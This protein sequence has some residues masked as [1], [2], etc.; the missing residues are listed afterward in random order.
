MNVIFC[1][2]AISD[3][4]NKLAD[5]TPYLSAR[6]SVELT[7]MIDTVIYLSAQGRRKGP[8]RFMNA[9]LSN[10]HFGKDRYHRLPPTE[11]PL[12]SMKDIFEVL[13]GRKE[14][15]SG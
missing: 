14:Y 3:E 9:G 13:T 2:H 5:I 11:I 4:E 6:L 12:M 8:E 10:T 1:A 7:G 15:D